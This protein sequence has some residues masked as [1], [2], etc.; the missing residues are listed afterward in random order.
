LERLLD[1]VE[2]LR[3]RFWQVAGEIV[4]ECGLAQVSFIAVEDDSAPAGA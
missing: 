1:R 3:L 4:Q 2:N